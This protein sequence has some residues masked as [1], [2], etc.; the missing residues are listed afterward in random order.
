MI[1]TEWKA[2]RTVDFSH[3]HESLASPVLVDGRNLFHPE[4]VKAAGLAYYAIGRGD[5]VRPVLA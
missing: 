2:F 3:L 1:C 4:T 5:S